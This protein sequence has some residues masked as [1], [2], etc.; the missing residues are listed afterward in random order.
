M[1]ENLNQN[2]EN[3]TIVK[4]I[5]EFRFY[6]M[7]YLLTISGH[8]PYYFPYFKRNIDFVPMDWLWK[9]KIPNQMI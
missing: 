8:E 7:L 2:I 5:D 4:N 6:S 3:Q 9:G 1:I